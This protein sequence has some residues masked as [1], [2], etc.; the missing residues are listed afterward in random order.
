MGTEDVLWGLMEVRAAE[1][2]GIVRRGRARLP[3]EWSLASASEPSGAEDVQFS[4]E[5]S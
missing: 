5:G 2:G 4:H 3:V 1:L